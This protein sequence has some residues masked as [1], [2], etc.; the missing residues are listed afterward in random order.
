M[1]VFSVVGGE[2]MATSSIFA[3]VVIDTPKA[4]EQLLT[5]LEQSADDEST[6]ISVPYVEMHGD[7]IRE[8]FCE[9]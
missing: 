4:A 1:R 9:Q 8:M 6:A 2:I 7:A 5:A 3:D